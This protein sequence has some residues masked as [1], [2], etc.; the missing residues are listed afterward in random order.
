MSKQT[1]EQE[2]AAL[3]TLSIFFVLW[4]V[5]WIVVLLILPR[6]YYHRSFFI[7]GLMP[8]AGWFLVKPR[9]IIWF[10]TA[11]VGLNRSDR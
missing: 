8:V 9:R 7:L 3:D 4:F 5:L 11:L 10:F 2:E 6:E 1:P